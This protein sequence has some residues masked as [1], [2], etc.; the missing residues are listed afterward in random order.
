[1][2]LQCGMGR[3]LLRFLNARLCSFRFAFRG[4]GLV[5]RTQPNARIHALCTMVACFCGGLL[6]ITIADWCIVLLCIGG[7]WLAEC[8]NTALEFLADHASPEFSPLVRD[9]KDAA[10]GGVLILSCVAA[11]V[12]LLVF[13]PKMLS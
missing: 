11:V 13:I 10:A 3:A 6:H 2:D 9:A 5:L 12:G 4:V 1:M 8:L 7:V